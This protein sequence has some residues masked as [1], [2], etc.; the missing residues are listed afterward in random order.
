MSS[1]TSEAG[2]DIC[3]ELKTCFIFLEWSRIHNRPD[4]FST[5]RYTPQQLAEDYERVRRLV[6]GED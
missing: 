6:S 2:K 3:Q 4:A 1:D 5:A